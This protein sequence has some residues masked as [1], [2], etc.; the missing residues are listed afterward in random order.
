MTFERRTDGGAHPSPYWSIRL[1]VLG[2]LAIHAALSPPNL[3]FQFSVFEDRA[4]S[5]ALR[6]LFELEHLGS[7]HPGILIPFN[8][9]ASDPGLTTKPRLWQV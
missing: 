7:W 9:C 4:L 3:H 6:P 1:P 8:S 5:V 2:S